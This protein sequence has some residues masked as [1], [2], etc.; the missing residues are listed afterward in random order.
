MMSECKK[1]GEH[2]IDCCCYNN[3]MLDEC[4]LATHLFKLSNDDSNFHANLM[5]LLTRIVKEI[6]KK[7]IAIQHLQS[8]I[9]DL[10]LL[11]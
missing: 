3:S 4:S 8:K 10:E 1:C 7:E 9:A 6:E 5:I 11:Q 2:I